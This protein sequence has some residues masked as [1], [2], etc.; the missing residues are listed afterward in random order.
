MHALVITSTCLITWRTH[1]V[2]SSK[3]MSEIGSGGHALVI[4]STSLITW[5][6]H[7]ETSSKGMTGDG[8]RGART[9]DSL[10]LSNHLEESPSHI[11]K[12]DDRRWAQGGTHW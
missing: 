7:G 11:L 1:G 9:G 4:L 8:L 2:V 3:G 10:N 5:R 6:G 12:S